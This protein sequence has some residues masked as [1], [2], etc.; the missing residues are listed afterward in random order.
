MYMLKTSSFESDLSQLAN[1]V[2]RDGASY[3]GTNVPA[4]KLQN[5]LMEHGPGWLEP[6]QLG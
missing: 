3:L 1:G 5:H 2:L 4:V 6:Y